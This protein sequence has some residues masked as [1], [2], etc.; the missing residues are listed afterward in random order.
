MV[1]TISSR[2]LQAD[3]VTLDFSLLVPYVGLT[4]TQTAAALPPPPRIPPNWPLLKGFVQNRVD[5][6][7]LRS[8][9]HPKQMVC[10]ANHWHPR[11][12]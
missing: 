12:P 6:L 4:T 1:A 3:V 2:Y 11:R 9:V 7:D 10:D 5:T 8:Q